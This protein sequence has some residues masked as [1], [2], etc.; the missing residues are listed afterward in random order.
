VDGKSLSSGWYDEILAEIAL[1]GGFLCCACLLCEWLFKAWYVFR[2]VPL[3]LC[4]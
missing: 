1:H 3:K 2:I 4:K